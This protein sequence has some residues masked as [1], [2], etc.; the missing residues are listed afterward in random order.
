MPV[1]DDR[2]RFENRGRRFD[3]DQDDDCSRYRNRRGGV[4]D[5]AQRAMVGV[6][7]NGMDVRHLDYGQQRKKNKT[8]EEYDMPG[9]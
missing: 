7:L 4:H 8:H 3:L 1:A 2:P 9:M 6:A 5:D